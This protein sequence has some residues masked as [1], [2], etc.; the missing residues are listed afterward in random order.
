MIPLTST[1]KA[2]GDIGYEGAKT[3]PAAPSCCSD[4][5][6]A[7]VTACRGSKPRG[8]G[9]AEWMRVARWTGGTV[10]RKW[11]SMHMSVCLS[12]CLYVCMHVCLSLCVR[13][14]YKEREIERKR[15]KIAACARKG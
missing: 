1:G 8:D 10:D 15:K 7:S 2:R 5:A 14:G 3:T 6:C 12:V 4:G 13:G 11:K 9:Y